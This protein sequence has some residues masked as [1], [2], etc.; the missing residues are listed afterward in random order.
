MIARGFA[1]VALLAC[2]AAS[3]ALAQTAWFAPQE[4]VRIF[5]NTYYVGSQ[6]LSAILI[7]SPQGHVLIDAPMAQ[8]A[9]MIAANIRTLGF[10]VE[11]IRWILNSHV[12]ADHAGATA[13]LQQLSD[14]A[15]AARAASARVLETGQAGPDDPQFGLSGAMKP[16][17]GPVRVIGDG[18]ILR[19]GS[20][21]LTALATGGHTPGGTSWSWRSCE[22][23]RC[24][25]LVYAD[26]LNAI[27]ADGFLYSNSRTYPTGVQDFERGFAALSAVPCD[28]LITPHPEASQ[29]WERIG[30]RDRG[31]DANALVG[32]GA[33]RRYADAGRARLQRR[34]ES[35]RET[36]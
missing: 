26:S 33:C 5:G 18:E 11:D 1:A 22:G 30:R 14:A 21:A 35:E 25:N 29:F 20:L 12:H 2:L 27:S 13:D 7:T 17:R 23:D 31:G 32:T 6:G 8:N 28:I 16:V 36:R 10:R 24:L 15:V 19:A 3:G 34:L 4:P 9:S